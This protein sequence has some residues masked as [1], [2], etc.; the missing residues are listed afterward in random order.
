M[1]AAM[2]FERREFLKFGA[3]GVAGILQPRTVIAVDHEPE[4]EGTAAPIQTGPILKVGIRGMCLL[5]HEPAK[6]LFTVHLLDTAKL[7]VDA[8]TPQL[9]VQLSTLDVD[10]TSVDPT[11]KE[12]E[13]T[14]KETW[15]WN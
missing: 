7:G 8:H 12:D 5:L 4:A 3:A 10:A 9:G 11:T 6:H 2:S 15:Y 14:S 1:E 13:G